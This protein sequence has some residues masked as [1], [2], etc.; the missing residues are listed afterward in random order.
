MPC[1]VT[2]WVYDLLYLANLSYPHPIP[3]PTYRTR[4][5]YLY[6]TYRTRTP[7][8]APIPRTHVPH[9]HPHPPQTISVPTTVVGTIDTR[10]LSLL[11]N[12][13]KF[14]LPTREEIYHITPWKHATSKCACHHS[15]IGSDAVSTWSFC[16]SMGI[17]QRIGFIVSSKSLCLLS[18]SVT[19]LLDYGS[20]HKGMCATYIIE[21]GHKKLRHG[22][23]RVKRG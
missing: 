6:R 2:L 17:Q 11:L 12:L 8:P 9:P 23:H 4:T 19:D 15:S 20:D 21:S 3:L 22:V 14:G 13:D 18:P 1:P 16:S 7:Y 10:T 5:P